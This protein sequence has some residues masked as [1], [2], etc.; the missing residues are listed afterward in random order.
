MCPLRISPLRLASILSLTVFVLITSAAEYK[1]PE[2]DA[3]PYPWPKG[4]GSQKLL[5][6]RWAKASKKSLGTDED[7]AAIKKAITAHIKG[8]RARVR[9]IRWLSPTLVMATASWYSG[10]EASAGY[11]YVVQKPNETWEI[12]TYYMLFVS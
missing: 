7:A 10:P 11:Y 8:K 6:E 5:N 1:W 3:D 2:R 12:L 9:E 4:E